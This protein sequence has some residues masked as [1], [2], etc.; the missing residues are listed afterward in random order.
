MIDTHAYKSMLLEALD[1]LTKE[2]QTVGIHDPH[3][4]QDWTPVPEQLDGNE[5]DSDLIADEVEDSDERQA[6]VATLETTYNDIMR[7]LKKIEEG[8]SGTCEICGGPIEEDR[9][10]ANPEART[11]K[12]HMN[13]ESTLDL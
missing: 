10:E 7:A 6:L 12:A 13:E 4:P 5:P 1:E 9:L 3:N 2:L 8:T 11:D